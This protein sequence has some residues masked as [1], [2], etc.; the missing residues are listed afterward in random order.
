[1]HI[2]WGDILGM[3]AWT[4]IVWGFARNRGYNAAVDEL[5]DMED[6]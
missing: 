6:D 5:M 1:M 3:V 2:H 4:W